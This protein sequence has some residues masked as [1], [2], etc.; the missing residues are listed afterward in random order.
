MNF[1]QDN[2]IEDFLAD[3]EPDLHDKKYRFKARVTRLMQRHN[4]SRED[5]EDVVTT[6]V[7]TKE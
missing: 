4:L 6:V 1:D 3:D 5:A 2:T 7:K